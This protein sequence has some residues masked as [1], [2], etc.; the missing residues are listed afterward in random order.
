MSDWLLGAA[1]ALWL[2]VL[3]SVSPCPL[4]TNIAAISYVGRRL[5]CPAKVLWA[6]LLYAAGRCLAYLGLGLVLVGSLL[7]APV[8]SQWLQLH[9][10]Q[11]LGP[12]LLLAGMVLLDLLPVPLAGGAPRAWVQRRAETWGLAGALLLGVVFALSLCPVSAALF[13]GSL[14]PLA[15]KLDSRWLLPAAYGVGTAVPVVVF[16]LLVA[17]GARSVARG[18]GAV[19]R[20]EPHARKVTGVLFVGVGIYYA[21][22][23]IFGL[24]P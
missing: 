20:L 13:F 17:G 16:S 11:L 8:L 15:V 10:N 24:L 22:R 12:L 3:T 9:M 2:G 19:T 23:F 4:A 21:L 7:S 5:D 1:S 6:G 18:F 14:L